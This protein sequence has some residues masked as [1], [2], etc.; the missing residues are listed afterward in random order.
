MK[1]ILCITIALSGLAVFGTATA[2]EGN[3]KTDMVP[4]L[5]W[6]DASDT[7]GK[8]RLT[9]TG[10]DILLLL[11]AEG[12]TPGDAHTIWFVI[13]N[14]PKACS[15]PACGEDDIFNPDGTPNFAAIANAGV[16]IA[17]ATGNVAKANGT[18]EFG[19]RLTRNEMTDHQVLI[20]A[21]A[22]SPYLLTARA[23]DAEVHLIVQT[24]GQAR[25]LPMLLDQ[26]SSINAACNPGPGLI[27]CADIQFAIHL[28]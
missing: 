22:S 5:S 1:K 15:A 10:D 9:R 7:G 27:G 19:A 8:S 4:V 3:S 12:L 21:G 24:H 18:A 16:A 25:S 28:P 20:P 14:N 2:G 23:K 11:E 6:L 26:L 13:F 17:N